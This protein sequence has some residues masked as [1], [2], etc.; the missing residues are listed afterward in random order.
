MSGQRR[1]DSDLRGFLR[2]R[3]SDKNNIG[4]VSENCLKSNF[5]GISFT[6]IYLRL[7]NAFD[8][9][10]DRIFKG[11]DFSLAVIQRV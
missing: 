6:V 4:I 7:L 8:L 9:I 10:F 3:L 11:D 1:I 5:V 2:S